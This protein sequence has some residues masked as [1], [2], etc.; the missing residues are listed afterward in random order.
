MTRMTEKM[1]LLELENTDTKILLQEMEDQITRLKSEA[2]TDAA[3]DDV[4]D[5]TDRDNIDNHN[6]VPTQ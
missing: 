1:K 3:T 4:D 6:L 2:A 5:N